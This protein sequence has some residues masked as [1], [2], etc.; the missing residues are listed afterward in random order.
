M[1]SIDAHYPDLVITAKK[2]YVDSTVYKVRFGKKRPTITIEGASIVQIDGNEV[3][4]KLPHKTCRQKYIEFESHVQDLIDAAQVCSIEF[5]SKHGIVLKC[6]LK[7][8]T[9]EIDQPGCYDVTL[10]LHSC[11]K[12]GNV[13]TLFWQL[14]AVPANS[15]QAFQSESEDDGEDDGPSQEEIDVICAET[16]ARLHTGIQGMNAEIHAIQ[17]R[18][19]AFT[20]FLEKLSSPGKSS[21]EWIHKA[22]L[23]LDSE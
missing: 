21:L 14:D 17:N 18:L 16:V 4:I 19:A 22:T 11:K 23:L 6:K 1:L 20:S 10:V 8:D 5:H 13:P 7:E 9:T 3:L 2:D 15:F 12:N